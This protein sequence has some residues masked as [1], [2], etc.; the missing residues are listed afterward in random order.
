MLQDDSKTGAAS[1]APLSERLALPIVWIGG[2]LS[3]G[4]ILV[5]LGLTVYSV[6]MRYVLSRPPVWAD[7]LIGYLLVAMVSLG[8]AEAYRRGNHISIE[9][10]TEALGKGQSRLRWIWSDLCVLAF[11]VVLGLSTWEAVEFAH[12]FGSYSSG[13]IEIETWKP[14]VPMLIGSMLLGL[15]SVARLIGRFTKGV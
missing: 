14:Q 2:I 11:S 12:S 8:V 15:F 9:I 7:E 6:F 5:T 10:L 4:L 1:A 13:A 3:A